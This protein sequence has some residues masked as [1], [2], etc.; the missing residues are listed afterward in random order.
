MS[1]ADKLP[2]ESTVKLVAYAVLAVAGIYYISRMAD[3][4]KAGREAIKPVTDAV[5][6]VISKIRFAGQGVEFTR[7]GF[8]LSSKYIDSQMRIAPQWRQSIEA[9]HPEHAALFAAITNPLGQ[10]KPQ[11]YPLID[12]EVSKATI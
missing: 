5:G 4:H 12:A 10:L 6:S 2:N 8:V 1:L 3:I 7:A 9:A 11:Y